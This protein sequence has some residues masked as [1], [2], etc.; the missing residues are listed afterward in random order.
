[1]NIKNKKVELLRLQKDFE[2]Y[3]SK[4]YDI[5]L[6]L[7]NTSDIESFK[8]YKF[9]EKHHLINLWQYYGKVGTESSFANL[10]ESLDLCGTKFGIIDS[11]FSLDAIIEG[12]KTDLFKKM[13]YRAG[14]LLNDK[15]VESI[16]NE[17]KN[18]FLEETNITQVFVQ[19]KNPLAVWILFLIYHLSIK[20]PKSFCLTKIKV[21]PFAASLTVVDH[22][23]ENNSIEKR[24]YQLTDII[25]KKFKVA[26]SFPCNKR[27]YVKEVAE[28]LLKI[29]GE[30]TVFYDNFYKAEL[31]RPNLDILLQDIY[32]Q[33]SELIVVFLC[34]EYDKKEWC[35]LEFRAIRD[36]IKK[37]NDKK[38]MFLRFDD[39]E[40][41][42]I[43]SID[44]Y[45]DL[46]FIKPEEA[47]EL[48]SKRIQ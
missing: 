43:F 7:L 6:S 31:A 21:D 22:L 33:N 19:N 28:R 3:S 13:A 17:I 15:E 16:G 4:Y 10:K 14:S 9:H 42:G 25:N 8:N 23:I 27:E 44:G 40:I 29:I 5:S 30:E 45:I 34:K 24:K 38:I 48:I 12:D 35:G 1:M 2:K 37:K 39:I 18:N 47:A 36:L 20:Q 26:L 11:E 41:K 46:T 32:H